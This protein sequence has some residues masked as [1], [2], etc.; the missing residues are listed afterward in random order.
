M[1]SVT[2][3][4][5]SALR[6]ARREATDLRILAATERLLGDG[7]SFTELSVERLISEA[8]I[9]RST[10]YAHFEDKGALVRRLA[11]ELIS[12]LLEAVDTWWEVA[13]LRRRDDIERAL[14]SVLDVYKRHEPVFL[15]LTEA[16]AYDESVA[17]EYR[18]RMHDVIDIGAKMVRRVQRAG[19]MRKVPARDTVSA[20]TW[21][22]ERSA[23]QMLSTD[24]GASSPRLATVL[25]DVIWQ[26][27][28]ADVDE[29]KEGR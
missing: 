20:L 29:T 1:A 22:V 8:G 7:A 15:A 27:L 10:F 14:G 6:P 3:T 17:A 4:K 25:T 24:S 19:A 2:K 11:G 13:E 23:Y 5:K 18:D 9:S 21:M 28:Y 12:E 16:S 26:T